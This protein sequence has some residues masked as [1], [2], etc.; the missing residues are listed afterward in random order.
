MLKMKR[1]GGIGGRSYEED[2]AEVVYVGELLSKRD[3]FAVLFS[4]RGRHGLWQ[5]EI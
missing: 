5:A 4:A 2:C 3:S 1:R